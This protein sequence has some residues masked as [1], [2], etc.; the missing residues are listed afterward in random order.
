MKFSSHATFT[1]SVCIDMKM[2]K[3]TIFLRTPVTLFRKNHIIGKKNQITSQQHSR[4]QQCMLKWS[5]W[6]KL[7]VMSMHQ[8]NVS[9]SANVDCT[10][11]FHPC[12]VVTIIA[13]RSID[14]MEHRKWHVFA[15]HWYFW[16]CAKNLYSVSMPLI[17]HWTYVMLCMSENV[18]T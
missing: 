14:F 17:L 1:A 6:S 18:I 12:A 4:L 8:C 16:L 13:S 7:T 15:R 2:Y 10:Y 3:D 11:I 5:F 9:A